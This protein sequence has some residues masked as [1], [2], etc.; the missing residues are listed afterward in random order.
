[1]KNINPEII[2]YL[3]HCQVS[4]NLQ[5][6][7]MRLLD[8]GC[9]SGQS[10]LSLRLSGYQA[11][12]V[13]IDKNA[14]SEGRKILDDHGFDGKNILFSFDENNPIP[15]DDKYFHF[16]FSQEVIEHVNNVSTMAQ[17]L[18]RV[19]FP[20]SF[21]F[22]VFR[23]QYNI[24]EPHFYMPF[25]HWLPKNK[26]RKYA[27]TLFAYLGIGKRP[28]EIS[29]AKPREI[30]NF[31]YHYSI[32]QTFYRP[33][34]FIGNAFRENGFGICFAATNHRSIRKSSLLSLVFKIPILNN[35]LSWFIMTFRH[36]YILTL[37]PNEDGTIDKYVQIKNWES[38]L[39]T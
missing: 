9:G 6:N 33:Y 11:F 29:K 4:M 28:P 7:N 19:S 34:Q 37:S 39:L 12:G 8:Y 2:R 24:I 13:D 1:M 23:P 31:Q 26:W 36:A 25:V 27:I 32:N 5:P 22:H 15:F 18:K 17:D 3:E 20:R 30:A 14:V 21:G 10:V 38:E 16:I 35:L